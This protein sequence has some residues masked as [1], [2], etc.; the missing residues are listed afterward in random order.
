MIVG[1]TF[2]KPW[3]GA[4]E[5]GWKFVNCVYRWQLKIAAGSNPKV[6]GGRQ[7]LSVKG[8]SAQ[9]ETPV[10]GRPLREKSWERGGEGH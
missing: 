5:E 9:A 7:V 2:L 1:G 3:E 10:E 8:P 4:G 6:K